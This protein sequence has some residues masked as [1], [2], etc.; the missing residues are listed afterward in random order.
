MYGFGSGRRRR[1]VVSGYEN[2]VWTLPI[3]WEQGEYW[4]RVCVCAGVG[5]VGREWVWKGGGVMSV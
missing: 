3:Q 5:S 4:T 2:W 1:R